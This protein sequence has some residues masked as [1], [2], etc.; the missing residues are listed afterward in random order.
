[1]QHSAS[2]QLLLIETHQAAINLY[3]ATTL[4]SCKDL[5]Y[6][7][8]TTQEKRVI[9]FVSIGKNYDQIAY[10]LHIQ[11]TTVKYHISNKIRKLN[12]NNT[13]HA[14]SL[15][16]ELNLLSYHCLITP[17]NAHPVE[18]SSSLNYFSDCQ[19]LKLMENKKDSK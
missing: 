8:L 13:Q 10:I 6:L 18:I 17:E 5:P 11:K 4:S 1:M 14:I 7:K 12:A 2:L 15:L 3:Q 19:P 9:F 16:S